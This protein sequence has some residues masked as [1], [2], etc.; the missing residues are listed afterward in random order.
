MS[1]AAC[2]SRV[3]KA[4]R[5]VDGVESVSVSLLT[6]S[7]I[8]EGTADSGAVIA[9]VEHAGYGASKK[10]LQEQHSASDQGDALADTENE[11]AAHRIA[12]VFSA[13]HVSVHGTHDVE[14]AGRQLFGK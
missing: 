12:P 2:S 9:A 1:C 13:A 4:V 14:L 3:E 5:A 6:N 7:M 11:T 8:V 10:G